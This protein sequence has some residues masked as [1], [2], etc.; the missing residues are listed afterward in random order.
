VTLGP[1]ALLLQ[2]VALDLPP[3]GQFEDIDTLPFHEERTLL[4]GGH[5]VHEL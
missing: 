1:I 2:I 5:M 4:G 3:I